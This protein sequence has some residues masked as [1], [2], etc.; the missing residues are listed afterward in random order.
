MLDLAINGIDLGRG[1]G[2]NESYLAGLISGLE[3]VARVRDIHVLV[4]SHFHQ[5]VPTTKTHFV[6]TGVY[7]RLPYLFW[8]QSLALRKLRHDWFLST[9]FLPVLTPRQSAVFVHDL[10]FLTLPGSYPLAIRLYMQ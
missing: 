1:R 8:T 4:G 7:H 9:F 10:S 3:Q 6:Q 5:N 2:G